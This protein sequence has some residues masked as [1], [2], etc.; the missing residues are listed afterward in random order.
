MNIS[1]PTKRTPKKS[2][3][4]VFVDTARKALVGICGFIILFS[5]LALSAM[6]ETEAEK[7]LPPEL[8]QI[9]DQLKDSISE[10]GLRTCHDLLGN[11][12]D[13]ATLKF[14]LFVDENFKNKSSNSSL[15]NIAI[16]RFSQYKRDLKQKFAQ[17]QPQYS[18]F[19]SV[20]EYETNVRSYYA[21]GDMTDAYIAFAKQRLIDEVKSKSAQKKTSILLEKYKVIAG[22]LRSLNLKV[23]KMYG[24]FLTFKNKLPC[25]ATQCITQ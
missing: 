6:A 13:I 11:Y 5:S 19:G 24:M 18:F 15:L 17:L 14:L 1:G 10:P 4:P 7:I 12:Y 9:E 2:L 3:N 22:Q 8:N 25:Y 23:A 20:E 21:C 16:A